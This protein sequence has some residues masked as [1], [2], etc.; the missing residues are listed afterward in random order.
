MFYILNNK[1]HIWEAEA[2]EHLSF[3]FDKWLQWLLFKFAEALVLG[4]KELH[5]QLHTS[6]GTTVYKQM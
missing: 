6:A 2:G 1:S 3:S 5:W 4:K